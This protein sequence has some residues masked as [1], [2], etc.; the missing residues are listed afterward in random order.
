MRRF[1]RPPACLFS[2]QTPHRSKPVAR[3]HFRSHDSL[4]RRREHA[5][6]MRTAPKRAA[7]FSSNFLWYHMAHRFCWDRAAR[8]RTVRS[9]AFDSSNQCQS[10]ADV[11]RRRYFFLPDAKLGCHATVF[12]LGAAAIT[13]IFCFLG[14]FASRLPLCSPFAM[15]ASLG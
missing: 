7:I 12:W 2:L 5:V 15:L 3:P 9:N 10:D 4:V 11:S 8:Q 14:F 1:Q 6:R 13:L